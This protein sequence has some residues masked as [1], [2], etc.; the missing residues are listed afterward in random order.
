MLVSRGKESNT[1]SSQNTPI[2]DSL[3][4][5]PAMGDPQKSKGFGWFIVDFPR[6]LRKPGPNTG[7]HAS[8]TDQSEVDIAESGQ[9]I[10]GFRIKKDYDFDWAQCNQEALDWEKFNSREKDETAKPNEAVRALLYRSRLAQLT[11]PDIRIIDQRWHTDV[12]DMAGKLQEAI[13]E[14]TKYI[15]S[16][17]KL[18]N[19]WRDEQILLWSTD[20]QL[21][22]P[23][24][25]ESMLPDPDP[26]CYPVN[27][28]MRR[29]N[30]MWEISQ[31]QLEA[32]L[33]L[34]LWSLKRHTSGFRKDWFAKKIF[35][36]EEQ[37]KLED[38]KS[39][40]RLWVTPTHEISS[41]SVPLPSSVSPNPSTGYL[42]F[43]NRS[44][45]SGDNFMAPGCYLS[46]LSISRLTLVN[47]LKRKDDSQDQGVMVL[48]RTKSSL[49]QLLAQDIFTIF[50]SRIADILERLEGTEKKVRTVTGSR[51]CHKRCYT[52]SN[53][54]WAIE[55]S[56]PVHC[57]PICFGRSWITRG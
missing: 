51:Q 2:P 25:A 6:S 41:E 57:R 24:E 15:F 10:V 30:G 27:F 36:L 50:I 43:S 56:S 19:H 18:L 31:Y 17:M 54:P 20:C 39:A 26:I 47:L 52:R 48:I 12:Q 33:G 4:Q 49:L 35:M 42:Q 29:F 55:R 11:G 14:S 13:Q 8:L 46:T 21:L 32:V 7:G 16:N 9:R 53:K 40:I 5:R 28:V 37:S 38:L 23:S 45:G 3:S 1:S 22:Q 44:P 34:W